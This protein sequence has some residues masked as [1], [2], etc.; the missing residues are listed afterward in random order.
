[1]KYIAIVDDEFISNFRVETE[2]FSTNTIL[3]V[4]DKAGAT[5]GIKLEPLC[6]PMIA[7]EDGQ[8]AYLRQSH[9]DCLIEMERKEM[10]DKLLSDV[11]I[12]FGLKEEE[13]MSATAQFLNQPTEERVHVCGLADHTD[14]NAYEIACHFVPCSDAFR[15]ALQLLQECDQ[16]CIVDDDNYNT[17][18]HTYFDLAA[19]SINISKGIHA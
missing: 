13:T 18:P 8:S 19:Y 3:V 15:V 10:Y 14:G 9:I 6:R 2:C 16:V 17:I 5:R 1:M 12:Q 4:T 11:M 7:T